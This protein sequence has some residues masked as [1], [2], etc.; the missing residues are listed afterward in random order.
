MSISAKVSSTELDGIVRSRYVDAVFEI[1]LIN[2]PGVTY[3]PANDASADATFLATYEVAAGTGG[4]SRQTIGYT[5][6]DVSLY[7]DDGVALGEKVAVFEQDGTATPI[8]FS[9]VAMIWGSGNP[10]AFTAVTT[11]VADLAV[12]SYSQT[13]SNLPGTGGSGQGLELSVVVPVDG[14]AAATL[15][16]TITADQ[17]GYGYSAGETITI[18]GSALAAAGMTTAGTEDLVLT[19]ATIAD[20]SKG[21]Q[22]LSVS[23]TANAVTMAAGSQAAFYFNLKQFGYHQV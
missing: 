15:E 18:A 4:Y 2:A 3:D 20:D 17:S 1:A 8:E 7:T 19:I 10:T 16:L 23:K 21:G 9:H 13:Y 12:D 5:S 6:A 14:T 11:P 22:I